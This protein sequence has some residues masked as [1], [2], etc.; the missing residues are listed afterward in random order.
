M[1]KQRHTEETKITIVLEGLKNKIGVSELCKKYGVADAT[2]YKWRDQFME[3]GKRGLM[4]KLESPN[5]D[6]KRK[7]SEYE[8]VIGRLTVQNEILKK[9][10]ED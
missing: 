9:T 7:I 3:A 8:N 6:L 10:F 1:A 2:F 5:A 4:G